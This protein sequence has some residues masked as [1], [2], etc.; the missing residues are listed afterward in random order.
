MKKISL[1]SL[2]ILFVFTFFACKNEPKKSELTST[3]NP[4]IDELSKKIAENPKSDSLYAMRAAAYYK[5]NIYDEAIK[6][7]AKALAIDT[8]NAAYHHILADIYMD[9]NDSRM[10]LRT[11]ERVVGLYPTRIPSLLKLAEFQHIL[12]Q[13]KPS[14]ES[15]AKV[16]Q[17]DPQNSEAFFMQGRNLAALGEK[18]RAIAA[19]K[20]CTSLDAEH[21]DAWVELGHLL[22]EKKDP[23]SLQY[24][25]TA[26]RIDSTNIPAIFG[27]AV[28]YSNK[29]QLPKAIEIYKKAISLDAQ[30]ADAYYNIGLL[31][32]DAKN[33]RVA[34]E[35]F[36][37]CINVDPQYVMSFFYRGVCA[38]ELGEMTAAKSD[39]EQTI[40]LFPSFE[41]AKAALE[42]INIKMK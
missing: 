34:K 35:N 30:N 23:N 10:A 24:F 29:G 39:Y 32:M 25:K 9:K 33:F 27:E 28:F 17:I 7:M 6:D 3:G 40:K 15:A 42:K 8:T 31:E 20:K 12:E 13:Y 22:E 2:S 14:I 11:M 1:I 5:D 38:E 18:D 36:N 19:F 16:L 26:Q 21:V 37:I 4:V 41:K